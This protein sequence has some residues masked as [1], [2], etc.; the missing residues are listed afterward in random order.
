MGGELATDPVQMASSSSPVLVSGITAT[1]IDA[2][3]GT[4][5]IESPG[6]SPVDCWGGLSD[7]PPVPFTP[8]QVPALN[9]AV[10]ICK[11]ANHACAATKAGAVKCWGDN[12]YGQL[13]LARSIVSNPGATDPVPGISNPISL[14]CGDV[15]TCVV[16]SDGA[17]HCWGYNFEGELGSTPITTAPY[18]TNNPTTISSF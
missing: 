16:T 10:S 8:A 2:S 14:D 18:G 5:I 1:A 11:G 15:H 4:C 17:V 6:G 7:T 3:F 13:G 12:R 9:D